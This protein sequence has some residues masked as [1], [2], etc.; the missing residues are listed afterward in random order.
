MSAVPGFIPSKVPEDNPIVATNGFVLAH[1][2]PP[3]RLLRV[4]E[5][6]WQTELAPPIVL[7][8][9]TVTVALAVQP[10]DVV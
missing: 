6:P 5:L 2:P 3:A 7:I 1:E 8:G 4:V 10:A 9:L